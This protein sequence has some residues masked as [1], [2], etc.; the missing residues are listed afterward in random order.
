MKSKRSPENIARARQLKSDG[1]SNYAIGIEFGVGESSIRQW[2]LSEEQYAA[3]KKKAVG[4]L[5]RNRDLVNLRGRERAKKRTRKEKDALNL[6]QQ[7]RYQNDPRVKARLQ[8]L[9]KK[10]LSQPQGY[11]AQKVRIANLSYSNRHSPV[12]HKFMKAVTGMTNMEYSNWFAGDGH[13]D[14]I[15]PLC[16]FDLTNPQHVVRAMHPS[17]MQILT[18]KQNEMKGQKGRLEDVMGLPWVGTESALV[19]AQVFIGKCMA[20][21]HRNNSAEFPTPVDSSDCSVK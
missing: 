21:L 2:F 15:V 18:R 8:E 6:K 16:S 17:N 20:R 5:Q 13:M 12:H 19:E 7:Q 1:W 11:L 9:A 10:Y 14:H 3:C 4:W